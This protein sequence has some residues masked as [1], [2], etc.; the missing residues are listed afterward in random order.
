[1]R[2]VQEPRHTLQPAE[3]CRLLD[4]N[5]SPAFQPTGLCA[6][7]LHACFT[8]LMLICLK[9]TGTAAMSA[10]AEPDLQVLQ[11]LS[12]WQACSHKAPL[13]SV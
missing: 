6:G 1:M 8:A 4:W 13:A 11:A 12:A 3:V 10:T 2:P 5:L 7:P 9:T